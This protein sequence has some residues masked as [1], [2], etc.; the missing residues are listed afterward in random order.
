MPVQ[1]VQGQGF[2][3]KHHSILDSFSK[4]CSILRRLL[5]T[6]SLWSMTFK[7]IFSP[8][9]PAGRSSR[10]TKLPKMLK[11]WIQTGLRG[12]WEGRAGALVGSHGSRAGAGQILQRV[13]FCGG[14]ASSS[15]TAPKESK[16]KSSSGGGL[17]LFT[18]RTDH[19][20]CAL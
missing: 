5:R 4:N 11:S 14:L 17:H 1:A 12:R 15:V 9:C 18:W 7:I 19:K 13:D 20:T 8:F 2:H 16:L 6:T 10:L 3:F